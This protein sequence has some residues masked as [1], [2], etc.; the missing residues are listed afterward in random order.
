MK[1]LEKIMLCLTLIFMILV[2][3]F[4]SLFITMFLGLK[5]YAILVIVISFALML[6]VVLRVF[7]LLSG[8]IANRSIGIVLLLCLLSAGAFE[9]Y[10]AYDRSITMEQAEVDLREYQPF[11]PD[12]KAV[13][14]AEE[15]SL[16][17]QDELPR[18]DGATAL[19]PLYAAFVQ[20]V[21]PEKTYHPYNSEVMSN[22]TPDAYMNLIKGEA[23]LIFAAAPSEEQLAYARRNGVELRL[24]P[25]GREAFVFFVNAKNPVQGLTT[26]QIQG[27]YSG[28]ITNWREVGGKNERIRAFQRPE[29][30]GSQTALQKLMAGKPLMAPPQE[31]IVSGM[32]GI[33]AKTAEYR[34]HR[35]AIGFSFRFFAEEMVRNGNIR[36]LAI[37][38]VYPARETIADGTYPLA[39]EFYA[40]TANTVN[41]NVERFIEWI[42]SP[43]GQSLVEKTGYTPISFNVKED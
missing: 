1:V 23:D 8:R 11:S 21:Y 31:D 28:T 41:P 4:I 2:A 39:S 35:N 10:Q 6:Y 7:G 5:L 18:I 22:T 3:G 9:I 25:I 24:T 17:L 29:G 16:K 27:I 32:G 13:R 26:E 40:V 34:N 36:L 12:T 42:L 30:S 15:S 33:I 43:Q 38:G 20:A 19:Y 14:L 37:D